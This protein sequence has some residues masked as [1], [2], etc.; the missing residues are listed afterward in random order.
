M[1]TALLGV[2]S[3][4]LTRTTNAPCMLLEETQ[5]LA[6]IDLPMFTLAKSDGDKFVGDLVIYVP[7]VVTGLFIGYFL[8]TTIASA[9]NR[10]KTNKFD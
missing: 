8:L 6:N 2:A 3:R 4:G 7:L 10:K 1:R 9:F 5:A